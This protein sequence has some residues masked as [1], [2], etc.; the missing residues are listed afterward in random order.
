MYADILVIGGGASGIT[1]AIT[2]KQTCPEAEVVICERLDRIGK[3]LLAT[4]NGRCNLSNRSMSAGNYHGSIRAMDI[5]ASTQKA[6]EFFA[7]NGLLCTSDEQGRMYPYSNSAA[8]V[9]NVLRTKLSVLNIKEQC[10]FNVAE[11]KNNNKSF[12][13]TSSEGNTISAKR[14]I[15]AAGGYAAPS[16]G[17][18]GSVLRLLRDMGYDISKLCPAVAPLK[19][20]PESV[21]GLKGVR[22]KCRLTAVSRGKLLRTEHGEVQFTD[23]SLSGIC[24]FNMAYLYVQ[25][26][27]DLC[28]NI[29]FAPDL[30]RNSIISYLTDTAERWRSRPLEELL[31]GMFCKNLAVFLV[32]NTCKKPM[33][34]PISELDRSD[35]EK[36]AANIKGWS[37]RITGCSSWQNAQSTLGGINRSSVTEELESKLHK[38]VFLC[39]EILDVAGDCGG[40]NLQWAWSSGIIAG[41]NCARSLKG[42]Q[43]DKNK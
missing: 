19:V 7:E 9:L 18:D 43:H 15:I 4:G 20:A 16:M 41:K 33:N 14:L 23:T 5:I 12:V 34:L 24:V 40:Y 13:V 8:S 25:Y 32:K 27:K 17:T 36:L 37:F 35:I 29:D 2:A 38:G 42:G 26:E 22:A 28:L 11:I 39:G 21:K 10:S 31:S 30:D 1:A 3:K 6:E